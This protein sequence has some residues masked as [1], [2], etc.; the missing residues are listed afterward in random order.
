MKIFNPNNDLE[1]SLRIG[2]SFFVG[3]VVRVIQTHSW[4]DVIVELYLWCLIPDN[5]VH[6]KC[7][8]HYNS[9]DS[10]EHLSKLDR[11]I[12]TTGPSFATLFLPE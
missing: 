12:Y 9:C 10:M 1:Y 4:F 5:G 8:E 11:I 2:F 6:N 7:S 3:V